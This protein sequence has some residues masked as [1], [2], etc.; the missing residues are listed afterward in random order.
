[1]LVRKLYVIVHEKRASFR[2]RPKEAG[3]R[4]TRAPSTRPHPG[5]ER[6]P[7]GEEGGFGFEASDLVDWKRGFSFLE[8]SIGVWCLGAHIYIGCYVVHWVWRRRARAVRC[9]TTPLARERVAR[10]K[11][12]R[13]CARGLVEDTR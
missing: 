6:T 8:K 9:S 3:A 4:E 13:E 2:R 10:D 11:K 7:R 1:M 12:E 5:K